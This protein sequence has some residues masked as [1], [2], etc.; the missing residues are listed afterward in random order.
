MN[1]WL[2][3]VLLIIFT[4]YLLELVVSL[5]NIGALQPTLPAE[6]STVYDE[7][8]YKNSQKYTRAT[9]TFS[10]MENSVSTVLTVLFLLFG[11][12]NY[13]D[14]WARNFGFQVIGTGLLF[15]G[16]LALLSFVVSLPFSIYSTFVIEEQFGFNRTSSKTF[17]LDIAKGTLLAVVIGAPLLSLV[18]WFF[19]HSG[20]YGWLYCWIG[21]VLFSTALQ[22]LAPVLIM[23]LFNKFS[24][25]EG[26]PLRDRILEYAEEQ[27]FRLQG[28]FTMDGSKRSSK[29]NAFFTGFGKFRK[30]VFY[31]TLLD[32]LNEAEIIAVLAHEM[33]HFKLK[34]IVKMLGASI[35]QTGIMFFLL[36]FFIGN[37]ELSTAFGMEKTSIYS[38]LV[39]FGYL[40]SPLSLLISILFNYFSRCNEFQADLYAA[41]S[42]EAPESLIS[43]LKKLSQANLSNLTPHPLQ[44]FLHYSHP[45]VLA[46]IKKLRQFS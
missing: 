4:S 42:T 2:L 21:V 10:L 32:K 14:I 35:G 41:Q 25:L 15:T 38:S 44:V 30:I 24:P 46:R 7:Q 12:F 18:L 22:F 11:G 31:D 19:L 36:S 17:I 34:H 28:I 8:E 9:T 43:S 5:L 23:P 29:L 26:G 1:P 20:P 39:F 33:G 45:P 27:N 13:V 37:S 40:Y 16:G 6:F 3:A